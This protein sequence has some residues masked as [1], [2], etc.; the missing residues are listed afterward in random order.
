MI[1]PLKPRLCPHC[2]RET[3]LTMKPRDLGLL[4]HALTYRVPVEDQITEEVIENVRQHCHMKPER[5]AELRSA[6]HAR[7]W[8]YL[9]EKRDR[10]LAWTKEHG[11][12]PAY[13]PLAPGERDHSAAM[14]GM[15]VYWKAVRPILAKMKRRPA[16]QWTKIANRYLAARASCD[17]SG[18]LA[19]AFAAEAQFA[20]DLKAMKGMLTVQD[21]KD[22]KDALMSVATKRSSKASAAETGVVGGRVELCAL[23]KLSSKSSSQLGAPIEPVQSDQTPQ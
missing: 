11:K 15:R 20:L 9:I 17:K 6:P 4:L 8:R 7:H 16:A 12:P 18:D 14:R 10:R 19:A 3:R 23:G 22:L 21:F 1:N 2:G 13:V 5:L